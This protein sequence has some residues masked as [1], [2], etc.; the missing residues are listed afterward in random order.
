MGAASFNVRRWMV[1]FGGN[2]V[3]DSGAKFSRSGEQ[4]RAGGAYRTAR[5][6]IKGK[7]MEVTASNGDQYR[8]SIRK[9]RYIVTTSPLEHAPTTRGVLTGFET[10][11]ERAARE[12]RNMST[13][14]RF[15]KVGDFSRAECWNFLEGILGDQGFSALLRLEE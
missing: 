7:V 11:K 10:Q 2:L 8:V 15:R 9:G 12:A 1:V 6:R 5:G 3:N 14:K 13:E 4:V